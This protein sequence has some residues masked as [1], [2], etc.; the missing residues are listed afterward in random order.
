MVMVAIALWVQWLQTLLQ[1]IPVTDNLKLF[2]NM[3]SIITKSSKKTYN[4]FKKK[5]YLNQV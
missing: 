3:F 5:L 1:T 2:Q 4:A